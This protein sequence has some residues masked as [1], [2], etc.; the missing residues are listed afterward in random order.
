MKAWERGWEARLDGKPKSANKELQDTDRD[1]W[2]AGW[3]A[4]GEDPRILG[5]RKEAT[6]RFVGTLD[7]WI[8]RDADGNLVHDPRRERAPSSEHSQKPPHGGAE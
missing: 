5:K 8:I 1:A 4:A 3:V 6:G 7:D 2:K